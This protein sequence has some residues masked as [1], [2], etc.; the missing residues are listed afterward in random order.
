[1][2]VS[3]SPPALPTVTYGVL[4]VFY[5]ILLEGHLGQ[6][7]GKTLFGIKVVRE[8]N[9]E[10]PGLRGATIRTLLVTDGLFS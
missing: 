8:D 3:P 10:V 6:T 1:M 7:V 2:D 5:Y 4:V 9:G